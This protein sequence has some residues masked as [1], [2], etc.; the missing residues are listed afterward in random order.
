MTS[1]RMWCGQQ[2]ARK[3]VS[4][5]LCVLRPP[6]HGSQA[7]IGHQQVGAAQLAESHGCRRDAALT[8]ALRP[9][10]SQKQHSQREGLLMATIKET[11]TA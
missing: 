2:T 5:T 7:H 11:K 1:V 3:A 8:A 6:R 4:R 10:R 9:A